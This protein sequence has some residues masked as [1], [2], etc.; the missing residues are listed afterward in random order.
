MYASFQSYNPICQATFLL[1]YLRQNSRAS[2]IKKRKCVTLGPFLNK[3]YIAPASLL[4][5][6]KHAWGAVPATP[7]LMWHADNHAVYHS[8][9]SHT[10][11]SGLV[12]K[13][14]STA[15]LHADSVP[16]SSILG[17]EEIGDAAGCLVPSSSSGNKI[18]SSNIE[19]LSVWVFPHMHVPVFPPVQ[20]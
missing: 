11:M 7:N 20:F 5:F 12:V 4:R 18:D 3:V 6:M 1:G 16:A 15:D 9:T 2:S 17:I 8:L 13:T 19:P 10:T 14:S